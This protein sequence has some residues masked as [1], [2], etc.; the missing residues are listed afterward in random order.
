MP[1]SHK[2]DKEDKD[3]SPKETSHKAKASAKETPDEKCIPPPSAD[4]TNVYTQVQRGGSRHITTDATEV[5]ALTIPT[6]TDHVYFVAIRVLAIDIDEHKSGG[7]YSR[8]ATF[9]NKGGELSRIGAASATG[10]DRETVAGW[11]VTLDSEED[12]TNIRVRVKGEKDVKIAWNIRAEVHE[13]G[14]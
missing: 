14:G 6:L 1:Y 7:S 5:T 2:E 13:F 3:D 10:T 11:D 8:E 9:K 12:K 4:S